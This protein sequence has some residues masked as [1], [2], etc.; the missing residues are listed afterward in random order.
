MLEPKVS[1][2]PVC[3]PTKGSRHLP[4]ALS[5]GFTLVELLVVIAIIG[6]LA[7]VGVPMYQGYQ[8]NA[9]VEASKANFTRLKSFIAAEITKCNTGTAL[10][11][12]G[13]TTITCPLPGAASY[14]TYFLAY[15]QAN[16]KNPYNA[17]QAAATFASGTG[18]P[19]NGE[20][21]LT[22]TGTNLTL[23]VNSGKTP[24]LEQVLSTAD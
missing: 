7:A 14:Q 20:V 10:S 17:S 4:S 5:A 16:F 18:T 22:V 11:A 9:R 6:I 2:G 13:T 23:I 12:I 21:R 15:I 19:G 3:V 24:N 8:E 1:F